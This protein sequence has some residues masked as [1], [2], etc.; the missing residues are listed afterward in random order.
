MELLFGV[1]DLR[2]ELALRVDMEVHALTKHF[3]LKEE[4]FDGLLQ[5]GST[6]MNLEKYEE[7]EIFARD[8]VDFARDE[9]HN[10]QD[11]ISAAGILAMVLLK[12]SKAQEAIGVCD[13]Y[14]AIHGTEDSIGTNILRGYRSDALSALDRLKEALA[15]LDYVYTSNC[16][17]GTDWHRLSDAQKKVG[18]LPEAI[19]S[20]EKAVEL[21][22]T[23]RVLILTKNTRVLAQVCNHLADLYLQSGRPQ[24][25]GRLARE[26]KRLS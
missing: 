11:V 7:A 4:H 8:A 12:R 16:T 24:D 10:A 3:E 13:K 23:D 6:L 26:A 17:Q 19:T 2:P 9:L 14:M 1:G 22:R 25:A 15:Q 20:M 5:L 18:Q 21:T